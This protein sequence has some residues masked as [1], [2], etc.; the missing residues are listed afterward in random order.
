MNKILLKIVNSG[1]FAMILLLKLRK[2]DFSDFVSATRDLRPN[3]IKLK[4]CIHKVY[5]SPSIL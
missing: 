1:D 3:F 4:N 2:L 5:D